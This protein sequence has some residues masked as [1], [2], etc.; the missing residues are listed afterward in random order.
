VHGGVTPW[1]GQ[2]ARGGESRVG[3]A[4]TS[5]SASV[6]TRFSH[7]RGGGSG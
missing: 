5:C 6:P 3:F 2:G 7:R 4:Y 1:G